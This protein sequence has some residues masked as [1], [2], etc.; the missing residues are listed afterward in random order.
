MGYA[1]YVGR[2][3]ALA[4]A[5]GIG[6]AVATTPG[7]AWADED[8]AASVENDTVNEAPSSTRNDSP[9]VH[10]SPKSHLGNQDP[11][12]T[13]TGSVT[14]ADTGTGSGTSIGVDGGPEV[15]LNTQTISSDEAV[16][17]PPT[18]VVDP[19]D[20]PTLPVTPPPPV[21]VPLIVDPIEGAPSGAV[22]GDDDVPVNDG[23]TTPNTSGAAPVDG[24]DQS[25]LRTF[26]GLAA[27]A[28]AS[29]R[30]ARVPS[31][32]LNLSPSLASN[33]VSVALSDIAQANAVDTPEVS[34][35]AITQPSLVQSLLAIP[36]TIVS[37]LL[38]LVT[39][40]ATPLIGPGAPLDSPFLYGALLLVRREFDRA[41]LSQPANTAPVATLDGYTT[42]EDTPMVITAPGLL[43][44]DTDA[45]GNALSAVSF[46]Q[47]VNGTLTTNAAGG[48]TY[49]PNLNFTG[50]DSF[51]YR[52]SDGT[53]S[54]APATVTIMVTPINDAPVA[55]A[56]SYSVALGT[57]LTI[58]GPGVL[59][60]DTDVDGDALT[61][62][63]VSGP[64]HGTVAVNGNGSFAYTPTA[65]YTGADS[66]TYRA[67]DGAATSAP[68]TVSITVVG[69][70]SAPVANGDSYTTAKDTAL[71]IAGPGVLGNDDDTDGDALTAA[72]VTGP[73]HGTVTV[74]TNG[75]FTYTPTAGY[76]GA[77]SFTYWASDG[78]AT[79]ALATV[80]ITVRGSNTGPLANDDDY[81]TA[82][83]TPLTIAGPGVLGNDID[84]DGDPLSVA[85]ASQPSRGTVLMNADGSFTYTP[86]ANFNGVDY[87][88]YIASD[89]MGTSGGVTTV[90]ITVRPVNDAIVANDDRVNIRV[91][92]NA[93]ITPLA[94]DID[95]DEPTT[96]VSVTVLSSPRNGTLVRDVDASF[97]Y[98]PNP[99]FVGTDSFT[100][101]VSDGPSS[102]TATVTIT[103]RSAN[104]APVARDDA[105]TTTQN[106]T[107]TVLSV[108]GND[109]DPDGDL[110]RFGP[111]A[112]QPAN[113]S[114][115]FGSGGTISYRPNDGFTGTD[116]FTY[117]VFDGIDVG[118]SATVTITVTGTANP[119]ANDDTYT[120]PAD[121]QLTVRAP[122]LLE[123]DTDFD[124]R[125]GLHLIT[126]PQNGYFVSF[127]EEG[128]FTYVPISGFSGTDSFTYSVTGRDSITESAP[129][130]VT[131]TV[132]GAPNVEPETNPF[133]GTER[134][135][136]P[137][138]VN[139]TFG[140][141]GQVS[142]AVVVPP[143]SADPAATTTYE[144]STQGPLG[145]FTISPD[146]TF[147]FTPTAQ[148]RALAE[149][150]GRT[151]SVLF[152]VRATDSAGNV[153]VV[154][155]TV[156]LVP[157]SFSTAQNY[158]PVRGFDLTKLPGFIDPAGKISVQGLFDV[159]IRVVYDGKIPVYTVQ[160]WTR[161]GNPPLERDS[162]GQLVRPDVYVISSL[163]IPTGRGGFDSYVIGWRKVEIGDAVTLKQDYPN[164]SGYINYNTVAWMP[165]QFP[166]DLFKARIPGLVGG[167]IFNNELSAEALLS[168]GHSDIEQQ[169]VGVHINRDRTKDALKTTAQI[170]KEVGGT[171]YGGGRPNP[172][173]VALLVVKNAGPAFELV[174]NP[175]DWSDR[176]AAQGILLQGPESPSVS[177]G[178][179]PGV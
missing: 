95:L 72:L 160:S 25:G 1:K 147:V 111:N 154:P 121:G 71:T 138:T 172:R 20:T 105:Y 164:A 152:Y 170:A 2:V 68:A 100:Y 93:Y 66:F 73:T 83:D 41:F 146:G 118:N 151:N 16:I 77:D 67:S 90:S 94:N 88:E 161:D 35:P 150:S 19:V 148:A 165:G 126:A 11:D 17:T 52:V 30:A 70:N 159:K 86:D 37:G 29:A 63:L 27:P 7:V 32:P 110:V 31:E 55:T 122:G 26:V 106:T 82:E 131:I 102:D 50:S 78:A 96:G 171:L 5:L 64:A 103:V 114:V 54:S 15:T 42:A 128:T 174:R 134:L 142:G 139:P 80:S 81:S 156:A 43:S 124:G 133:T 33:P 46:T 9:G 48:F 176:D 28:D 39:A 116:S 169:I 57:A 168:T 167:S 98:T 101:S 141:S 24:G 10:D 76:S 91:N 85:Y 6:T 137:V 69:A 22:Q 84:T 97:Y 3:G 49:S 92:T 175:D 61:A 34:A 108:F 173:D 4:V 18:V 44:N 145:D 178:I 40:L 179:P 107:L 129:A 79:S 60:N 149:E 112:T 74:D 127:T 23:P 65:G 130:T 153:T 166:E 115:A 89:G 155:V 132:G 12:T 21:V 136:S 117:T 13:N 75:S 163:K 8:T 177:I 135:P 104:S 59:S 144:G 158:A 120:V 99:G 143:P 51:T 58:A 36:V 162:S 56:D 47:P 45:D 109:T 123:N 113:G 38:N 119:V 14:G 53:V 87:F 140:P 125:F 62:A 157:A